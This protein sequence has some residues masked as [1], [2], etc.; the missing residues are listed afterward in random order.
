[1]ISSN[2]G[3]VSRA[4]C[5]ASARLFQV[6]DLLH[7][8]RDMGGE[9]FAL[10]QQHSVLFAQPCRVQRGDVLVFQQGLK[11]GV[12]V[13]Q[14]L[15]SL[16]QVAVGGRVPLAVQIDLRFLLRKGVEGFGST[17]KQRQVRVGP[18][19]LEALTDVVVDLVP[20]RGGEDVL[21]KAAGKGLGEVEV[22]EVAAQC[23]GGDFPGAEQFT[24][25]GI[26]DGDVGV[27]HLLIACIGAFKGQDDGVLVGS[28]G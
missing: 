12:E 7:P 15:D 6:R 11:G 21:G 9:F 16:R 20:V 22:Y 24:V 18:H 3:A 26:D 2:S 5:S 14:C 1:M 27:N 25:H 4:A 28:H 19:A 23:V 13:F 8:P 10:Q 17:V